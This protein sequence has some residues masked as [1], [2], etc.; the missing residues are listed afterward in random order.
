MF[1]SS[2]VQNH[3]NIRQLEFSLVVVANDHNPT[4]LNPDF[5]ARHGIVPESRGW[6][7]VEPAI[8]TPPFAVVSYDSQVTVSVEPNRLKVADASASSGP[9]SSK[10]VDIARKYVEV[11]PHVRYTAAGINFR[12]FAERADANACLKDRFLKSGPWDSKDH[13]LQTVGLKLVYTLD[14]GQLTLSVESEVVI[15]RLEG[16]TKPAPGILLNANFHRDCRGYRSAGQA[17]EH[18]S[19]ADKDWSAYQR[20]LSD[21]LMV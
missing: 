21:L 12:S 1:L 20:A 6:R 14:G 3:M 13:P 17:L 4:I 10:A 11:L 2:G 15:Q 8:T 19:N 16:E 7:V 18:M 9:P 5:L